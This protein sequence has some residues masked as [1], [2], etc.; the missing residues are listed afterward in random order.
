MATAS[1]NPKSAKDTLVDR[2]A[3]LIEAQR[4]K[5]R[6]E[7]FQKAEENFERITKKA[8]A[9]RARRRETA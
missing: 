5:L 8:R 4:K 7:Q 1:R 6:P 2:F 9:A 3:A